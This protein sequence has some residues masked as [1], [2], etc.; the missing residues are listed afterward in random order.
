MWNRCNV[1][2]VIDL[3]TGCVKRAN[4]RLPPRPRPFNIH[5]QIFHTIFF[6]HGGQF[7]GRHLRCEWCALSGTPKSAAASSR[8]AER[9][10]LTIGDRYNR[11]VKRCVDVCYTLDY[12]SLYFL[13]GF[14][15]CSRHIDLSH[16]FLMIRRGPLR[17]REFVRV[18]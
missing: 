8:P 14:S 3:E 15:R 13:T 7:F 2:D 18:L 9:I 17:V 16:F 4:S 10:T 11:V 12:R 6:H 1:R 5:I